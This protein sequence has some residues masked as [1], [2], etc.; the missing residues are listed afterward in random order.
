M[1]FIF[2]LLFV[3][4][5][6][7]TSESFRVLGLFPHP[8]VSHFRAFQPLLKELA[9]KGHD[10]VVVSHFPDGSSSKNYRDLVLDQGKIMTNAYTI[11]E[12]SLVSDGQFNS[13]KTF[14]HLKV[15]AP[16]N[17]LTYYDEFVALMDEGSESCQQLLASPHLNTLF[18][19]SRERKFDVLI[20]EY[21]NTDCTLGVAYQLNITSF[22]GM[23]RKTI[24]FNTT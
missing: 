10:V 1:K 23:V 4:L 6:S 5:R 19:L 22:I 3:A 16:R 7:R 2:V 12:V 8:A 9:A 17:I 21:F 18:D 15:Y 11:E 24:T 14:R 13:N 20:T